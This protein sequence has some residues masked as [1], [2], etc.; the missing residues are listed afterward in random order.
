[1][2]VG[3]HTPEF[4][5]EHVP[6]NVERAVR[7]LDV[8]YPVALDN[9]YDTWQAWG[10]QYWPA[11]YFVDRQGHVRFAHF[12][13]GEYERSENV[14]RTLLAEKALPPPV[15]GSLEDETPTELLTPETYLGSERIDRFVGSRIVPDK[16]ADY[17][18]PQAVPQ[19]SLAYGGRWTVEKERIVAGEDARLRLVFHARKVFLV[20]GGSGRVEVA[21]D[22]RHVRMVEVTEDR[23][24]TLVELPGEAAD[25][26]LDLS[27]TPGTEAYAFTFG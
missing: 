25:H 16:E 3:V 5:F 2:V 4:A 1:V 8:T 21:V 22:G 24:Y 18:I 9:D 12:G 14:I 20:L 10:N 19:N 11:K 26:T 27:F 13:E 7:S 6:S 23:L 17:S 15:S